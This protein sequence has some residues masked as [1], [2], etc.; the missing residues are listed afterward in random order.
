[1]LTTRDPVRTKI[2]VDRKPVRSL[3]VG[4]P[5]SLSIPTGPG[6]HDIGV[7]VDRADRGLRV[8]VTSPRAVAP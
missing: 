6:W 1:M 3:Q 7:D 2:T 4:G 5:V 8:E